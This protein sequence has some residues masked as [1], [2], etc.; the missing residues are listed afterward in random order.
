MVPHSS[1]ERSPVSSKTSGVREHEGERRGKGAKGNRGGG[2]RVGGSEEGQG[3][4]NIHFILHKIIFHDCV[5]NI[6][7]INH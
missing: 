4:S 6:L 2:E 1:V 7:L 5:H 3:K